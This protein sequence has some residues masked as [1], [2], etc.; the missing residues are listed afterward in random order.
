MAEAIS[1]DLTRFAVQEGVELSLIIES[2]T[3][4][5]EFVLCVDSE[6]PQEFLALNKSFVFSEALRAPY[7][8][9]RQIERSPEILDLGAIAVPKGS[10]RLSLVARAWLR[11]APPVG[12]VFSLALVS[13]PALVTPRVEHVLLGVKEVV[14]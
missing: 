11:S 14:S 2:R 3:E 10:K 9:V 4:A 6:Q 12:E 8:Y 13:G 5:K 1:W 7:C